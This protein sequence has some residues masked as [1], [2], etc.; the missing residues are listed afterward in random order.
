MPSDKEVFK[1]DVL[2]SVKQM[3]RGQAAPITRVKV[4]QAAEAWQI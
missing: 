2:K 4:L 1:Q 3:R